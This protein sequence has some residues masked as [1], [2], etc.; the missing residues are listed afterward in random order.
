MGGKLR[1][2]PLRHLGMSRG[3]GDGGVRR[4]LLRK[5]STSLMNLVN[6]KKKYLNLFRSNNHEQAYRPRGYCFNYPS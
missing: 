2:E 3:D 5:R 1:R 6:Y 4:T